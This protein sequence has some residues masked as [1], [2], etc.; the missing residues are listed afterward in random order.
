MTGDPVRL[1]AA[2]GVSLAYA[3]LCLAIAWR[4]RVRRRALAAL[5]PAPQGTPRWIV[6]YA[7]QTG[8][9]E[10]LAWQTADALHLAGQAAHLCPLAEVDADSLRRAERILFVLSTYGEGN[11]PDNAANFLRRLL[12][13]E[14]PLR[15]LHYA[16]LAL[17][18]D[19]YTHFC[20]FGRQLDECLRRQ[21][22]QTLF[23]RIEVN[24]GDATA[25]E[26]WR[27]QLSHLAGTGDAP[28]W[29]APPFADWRLAERRLLNPGSAG[30]PVY[31]LELE[32]VGSPLPPWSSGDLAQVLAPGDADRPR[33]YSISSIPDDGRLHLLVRQHR[34]G[35]G[36]LGVASGWLTHELAP[37]GQLKLRLRAHRQFQLGANAARPLILIG[38][39]TGL[40]GLR[41]HLK[42]RANAGGARNWLIFGERNAASDALY[43]AD[44]DAWRR[45]GILE[46]VDLVF[47]RDQPQ[48]RYVQDCLR[49]LGA[50]L[51][52]W[53][54][55]GAAIYVCGSLKGMASG[56]DAV[57]HELL[58]E[59]QL[60]ALSL[61]GRYRRDVY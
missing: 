59:Q 61:A 36:A 42:A 28:D 45:S 11:P 20:A 2:G 15:Q 57:L 1:L 4:Q 37:G 49:E 18:D 52:D 22:A 24:R 48:R 21:G 47:S 32:P 29:S 30:G 7:S 9:A 58:G 44:I 41:G 51:H 31:H 12:A 56:V 27:K 33:E 25:V 55:Q 3:L 19:S 8:T 46:R 6:A 40:A 35:D 16:V 13:A 5:E 14:T 50:S 60:Q 43:R 17:G 26:A 38:N 23:A 10:A 53:V 54:E 39:G 34:L